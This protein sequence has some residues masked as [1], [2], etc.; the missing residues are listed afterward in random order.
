MKIVYQLQF[1]QI[2]KYWYDIWVKTAWVNN[3]K[4]GNYRKKK[5]ETKIPYLLKT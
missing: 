2:T 3:M 5:T 4:D 1:V